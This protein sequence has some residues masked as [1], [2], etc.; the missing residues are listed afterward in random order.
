MKRVPSTVKMTNS[1]RE[2]SEQFNFRRGVRSQK[3][4]G[5]YCPHTKNLTKRRV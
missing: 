2:V 5:W 4:L 3:K 1:L